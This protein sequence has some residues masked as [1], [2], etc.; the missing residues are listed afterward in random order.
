MMTQEPR[1]CKVC[2]YEIT[3]TVIDDAHDPDTCVQYVAVMIG[4]KHKGM[5]ATTD[6]CPICGIRLS[7]ESTSKVE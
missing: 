4:G 6:R 7:Q 2:G 3:Y 5:L 1:K